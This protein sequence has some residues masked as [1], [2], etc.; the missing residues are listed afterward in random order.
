MEEQDEKSLESSKI[1]K[2]LLIRFL[3]TQPRSHANLTKSSAVN[4]R[5]T[6]KT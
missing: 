5:K 1:A 2:V 6:E 4:L 3:A